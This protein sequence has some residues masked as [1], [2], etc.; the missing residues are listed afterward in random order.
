M[1]SVIPVITE[2]T[3]NGIVYIRRLSEREFDGGIEGLEEHEAPGTLEAVGKYSFVTEH[4]YWARQS[5]K[6]N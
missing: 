4:F 1:A 3:G 6:R 5:R 2:Q